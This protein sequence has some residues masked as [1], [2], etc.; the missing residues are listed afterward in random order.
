MNKIKDPKTSTAIAR[1]PEAA[2]TPIVRKAPIGKGGGKA[3]AN[4]KAS[5]SPLRGK[6]PLVNPVADRNTEGPR[7]AGMTPRPTEKPITGGERG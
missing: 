2:G 4:P 5:G 6:E 1:E 3:P 7:H